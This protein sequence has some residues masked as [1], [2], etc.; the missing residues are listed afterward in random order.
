MVFSEK[1]RE[2]LARADRRWNFKT[3][4][5]RS[6]KTF[7]DLFV[8]PRRLR[9]AAGRD[10]L[11]VLIGNTRG[12]LER[13]ILRPLRELWGPALVSDMRPDGS[14][15]L[16]GEDV[17]CIGADRASADRLRGA[18]LK[19]CYGDE[20]ATWSEELFDLLKSRL[21]KPYSRF[22][23]TCNPAAPGHWLKRFLDSGADVFHQ[24]YTLD[25][26]PFLDTA[27]RDAIKSEYAGT[28]LYDRYVL[29]LWAA[30]EGAVY[31]LFAADPSRFILSEPP[32]DILY[33]AVGVDFGGS[34]SAHSFTLTGFTRG[35]R[36]LVVLDEFYH[37]PLR[38]GFLSPAGLEDAFVAFLR[39]ARAR[40]RV[41]EVFCDSAEQVLI[42]GFRRA[43]AA[44]S[45]PV[46][47]RNARKGPVNG[48]IALINSLI[49][50]GRFFVLDRCPAAVAALSS[51]VYAPSG[52][53][54]DVR[55]DD[56]SLNVDSLDSL[57]YSAEAVQG[58][59][60]SAAAPRR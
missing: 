58:A 32:D 5:T 1:Q 18:S 44:A 31:P 4:A 10:G 33:A 35:F 53:G 59:L 52:S 47:V 37:H 40:F 3:G 34:V 25:D 36:S 16:F 23:G 56:G 9:A 6:G 46:S 19:Y 15:R 13:N 48:R 29:G 21:D 30:A 60:M 8:I 17:W 51:A 54:R 12:S 55:L 43:A 7:V 45:L 41:Y 38:S 57:E 22:D 14:A 39:R 26:N 11:A 27:V 50:R 2:Y 42:E 49:A 24:R 28:V 20:V